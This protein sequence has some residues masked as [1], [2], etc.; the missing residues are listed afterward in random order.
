MSIQLI[1]EECREQSIV[2]HS[3]ERSKWSPPRRDQFKLVRFA[4]VNSTETFLRQHHLLIIVNY[5][6]PKYFAPHN[7][8]TTPNT[9]RPM[10]ERDDE[11]KNPSS[12]NVK[13]KLKQQFF[14]VCALV[15]FGSTFTSAQP[16]T[17]YDTTIHTDDRLWEEPIKKKTKTILTE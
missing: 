8:T 16:L 15:F 4:T 1:W 3:P 13:S 10:S 9:H 14:F 2:H 17:K 11:T 6:V 12:M 7:N 5:F